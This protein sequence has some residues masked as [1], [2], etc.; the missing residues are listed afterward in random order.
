VN[1]AVIGAGAVGSA[2]AWHVARRGHTVT[3]F[4]QFDRGHRLGSSHGSSRIIRRAYQDPLYA[5]LIDD[6]F[7]LWRELEEAAGVTVYN[8]TGI[9]VFGT[10]DSEYYHATRETMRALKEPYEILG[11]INVAKRFGGFHIE[12]DEEAIFQPR[13]GYLMADTCIDACLNLATENGAD[14]R[15]N[16]RAQLSDLVDEFD[17][18][19]ICAGPWTSNIVVSEIE[20]TPR[21]Q[22]FAYFDA[23]MEP[24]I[25]V[26]IDGSDNHFYGFPDYGSGFKVGRH[27]YGPAFD[28]DGP[29]PND[30][31][32]LQAIAKE[33]R[34]RIGADVMLQ[35][36]ECVYTVAPNEDFRIGQLSS[37]KPVFWASPCSGHGFKFAIWFGR[38][39][40][41]LVDGKQKVS[42]W[43]RFCPIRPD[44][45]V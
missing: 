14:L 34:R 30:E 25:P 24:A 31:G 16:S 2:S 12:P 27:L 15:F 22:R 3:V 40:A 35:A 28:A 18:V 29:R 43:P 7:P 23:P 17:A 38:L 4:E 13:A 41:D 10:P 1:V 26:W 9:L 11:H 20:L 8:E 45:H 21:L 37:D 32:A 44:E 39:M 42:D 36:H 33:A 6:V 19:V 5:A